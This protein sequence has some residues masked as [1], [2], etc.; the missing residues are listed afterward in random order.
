MREERSGTECENMKTVIKKREN[1]RRKGEGWKMK[2]KR[3][4]RKQITWEG[5]K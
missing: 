1:G 5:N 2:I 3:A 4:G